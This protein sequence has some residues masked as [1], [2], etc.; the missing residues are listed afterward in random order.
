M[1]SSASPNSGG[2]LYTNRLASAGPDE[3]VHRRRKGRDQRAVTRWVVGGGGGWVGMG[4]R[5][6]TTDADGT[7][8][9][10]H[11]RASP[12]AGRVRTGAAATAR[13][14]ARGA[15]P[16]PRAVLQPTTESRSAVGPA[17]S[18]SPPS[19]TGAHRGTRAEGGEGG[20]GDIVGGVRQGWEVRTRVWAQKQGRGGGGSYDTYTTRHRYHGGPRRSRS[21][22]PCPPQRHPA[23]PSRGGGKQ[24][25]HASR[26]EPR[27][28]YDTLEWV[29]LPNKLI[30]VRA[31]TTQRV[32]RLCQHARCQLTAKHQGAE[33]Q[34]QH[35]PWR[36]CHP[37]RLPWRPACRPC[38]RP[39]H[40]PYRRPC[41]RPCRRPY[42]R[43]CHLPCRHPCRRRSRRHPCHQAHR[44]C[45]RKHK[46]HPHTTQIM[47][48]G[49][50]PPRHVT[51][52]RAAGLKTLCWRAWACRVC[53][54]KRNTWRQSTALGCAGAL[55]ACV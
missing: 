9:M 35:V 34:Q 12:G 5:P 23:R 19:H 30:C 3:T 52:R 1:N 16:C 37:W 42:H 29:A 11:R 18:P 27:T 15:P 24:P 2:M 55:G 45:L 33:Q 53:V 4:A 25:R 40:Q 10:M 22:R 48:L 41:R 20:G 28:D 8:R 36:P 51:T 7:Q 14:R 17:H 32:R 44:P 43:P 47:R 31:H 39:C 13:A 46:T 21:R 50:H 54:W 26:Q 49:Q 6:Q 38:R